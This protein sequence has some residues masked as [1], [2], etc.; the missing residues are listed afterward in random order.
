MAGTAA[1]EAECAR[2]ANAMGL[3]HTL[4]DFELLRADPPELRSPQA[5]G[6]KPTK[7]RQFAGTEDAVFFYVGPPMLEFERYG[8][9]VF[10]AEVEEEEGGVATPWDS[11]G[12]YTRR[13]QHLDVAA[14]RAL[15]LMRTMSA[16]D[17]RRALSA[18]LLM[19]FGGKPVRYLRSEPP[20]EGSDPDGVYDGDPASFT[21]EAR[22]SGRLAIQR[23]ELA[24][25]VARREYM[26]EGVHKLRAW[27]L[28]R[29]VRFEQID[30]SSPYRNV[31][32][33]VLDYGLKNLS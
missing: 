4:K 26:D 15:L 6:K 5:L 22:L 8:A 1:M 18:T 32:D 31:R 27:C 30:E 29:K 21:Y 28:T 20:Q 25:V 12:L 16:P 10:H 2:A 3:V 13:A 11:G 24:L 19:R 9:L 23:P 7:V 33:A 14:R 17:Y